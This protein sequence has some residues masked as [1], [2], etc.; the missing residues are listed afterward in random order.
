MVENAVDRGGGRG[1]RLCPSGIDLRR[2]QHTIKDAGDQQARS[3]RADYV[4]RRSWVS[5]RFAKEGPAWGE[6]L[7]ASE[8]K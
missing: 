6:L 8:R 7:H 3:C 5:A 4:R 1:A 2:R